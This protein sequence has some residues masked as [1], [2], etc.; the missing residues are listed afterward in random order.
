[1][2]TPGSSSRR[3]DNRIRSGLMTQDCGRLKFVSAFVFFPMRSLLEKIG[4]RYDISAVA[5]AYY[6]DAFERVSAADKAVILPHCLIGERCKARFSKEDGILCMNCKQCRCGEIRVLCEER[7]WRFYISPSTNF[8]KRLVRRKG[9]R[10]AIGAACDSEIAK[11]IRSTPITLRGV[12]L[13]EKKVIPQVIRMVGND[14]LNNEID[15]ELLRGMIQNGTE[16]V[17]A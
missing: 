3:E 17:R 6:R 9:I 5:N 12:R 11:G 13:K 14:C 15:W 7:G 4:L 8:T 16:G 2:P 1:M 10:A